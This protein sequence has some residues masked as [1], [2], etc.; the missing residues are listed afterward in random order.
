MSQTPMDFFFA[1]HGEMIEKIAK[2]EHRG[3]RTLDVDDI[4]QSILAEF[5]QLAATQDFTLWDARGIA[6][7][8]G[9]MAR[10]YVNR[11]RTDYMHFSAN[12]IYTPELV[13]MFLSECIWN[14]VDDVPDIDGRVDV[15]REFENLPLN[16]RQALFLKYGIGEQFKHSDPRRKVAER[17]VDRLTSRLN[18]KAPQEWVDLADAS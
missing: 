18:S 2:R 16:Q 9:K 10:K 15:L 1:A 4:Y 5:T 7:L 12:F 11:E 3:L 13:E 8:A 17:A 14:A 6:A